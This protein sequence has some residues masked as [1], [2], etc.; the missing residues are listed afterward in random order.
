[1]NQRA[2]P[3]PPAPAPAPNAPP[4]PKVADPTSGKPGRTT[5]KAQ[6]RLAPRLP[7]ERDESSDSQPSATQ[8]IIEQARQDV[9]RGLVDTDRGPVLDKVYERVTGRG[10]RSKKR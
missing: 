2:T 4:E 9:Q 8:P 10:G 7:H 5:P 3:K 6:G 1:M